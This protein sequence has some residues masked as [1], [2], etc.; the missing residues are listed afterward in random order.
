MTKSLKSYPTDF[1]QLI[2]AD[3]DSLLFPSFDSTHIVELNEIENNGNGLAAVYARNMLI[4][5]GEMDWTETIYIPVSDKSSKIDRN[6]KTETV[7]K[8]ILEVH[9][10]P[11]R[12]YVTAEY[13]L[14][15]FQTGKLVLVNTEGKMVRQ[16]PLKYAQDKVR[17][18]IG[19]LSN[20]IYLLK[21]NTNG[22][23]QQTV[24]F[25]IMK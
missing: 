14:G 22:K 13:H 7:D 20:G 12:D 3:Q 23:H 10:N 17:I 16:L 1:T 4:A 2:E 18:N 9:P 25:N 15:D 21:L 11:A 8:P 24:K 19:H 6:D 5:A